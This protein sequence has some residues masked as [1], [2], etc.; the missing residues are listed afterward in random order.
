MTMTPPPEHDGGQELE[1]PDTRLAV[2]VAIRLLNDIEREADIGPEL[3]LRL[4]ALRS[5]LRRLSD[6]LDHDHDERGRRAIRW[7][8]SLGHKP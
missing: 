1:P 6:R 3:L 8:R 2:R 4:V 7:L 5:V